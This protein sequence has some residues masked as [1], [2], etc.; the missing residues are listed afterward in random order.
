MNTKKKI[1]FYFPV[2]LCQVHIVVAIQQPSLP[3][4]TKRALELGSE[5]DD[6]RPG[7]DFPFGAF[8]FLTSCAAQLGQNG[9]AK[10]LLS[11]PD[12]S[13]CP[14]STNSFGRTRT[15]LSSRN[16][17]SGFPSPGTRPTTTKGHH[18]PLR[19]ARMKTPRTTPSAFPVA[20]CSRLEKKSL[21]P[22]RMSGYGRFC[23]TM[24]PSGCPRSQRVPLSH[25]TILLGQAG[26][27]KS[28]YYLVQRLQ[29]ELV[30]VYCDHNDYWHVFTANGVRTEP[31]SGCVD[32]LRNWKRVVPADICPPLPEPP[33]S[34]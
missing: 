20:W 4:G 1:S 13:T 21:S 11:S 17:P 30:T 26:I 18:T 8:G 27:G 34:H 6:Q 33:I 29:E 12:M 25:G 24:T 16:R 31:S 3:S 22:L 15:R 19:L 23:A 2:P 10:C 14:G 5:L 32:V 9:P 7:W 28:C